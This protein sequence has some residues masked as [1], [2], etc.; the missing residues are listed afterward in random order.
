MGTY[1]LD[2]V[3][4]A[5]RGG[6]ITTEQAVGQILLLLQEMDKRLNELEKLTAPP[7]TPP[8]NGEPRKTP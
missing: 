8:K 1:G 2:G 7:K 3:L 6:T 5:W 4:L